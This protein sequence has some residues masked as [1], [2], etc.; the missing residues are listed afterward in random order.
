MTP[1]HSGCR[2]S[3]GPWCLPLFRSFVLPPCV[4]RPS[5]LPFADLLSYFSNLDVHSDT[6]SFFFLALSGFRK[7]GVSE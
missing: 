1:P 3:V 4:V 6:I 7:V 2:R 5:I